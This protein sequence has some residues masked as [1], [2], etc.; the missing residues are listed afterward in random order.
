[1]PRHAFPVLKETDMRVWLAAAIVAVAPA[2]TAELT[3]DAIDNAAWHQPGKRPEKGPTALLVKAQVLLA[4]AR[5]SPGEIDG[6]PGAN[7]E[8]AV[9]AFAAARGLD[10]SA[11]LT[12]Q[13]WRELGG[14]STDPVLQEYAL[15]EKDVQGPYLDRV[16]AK[17]DKMKGLSRM[18]YGSAREAMA[19][20]FHMSEALLQKLNPRQTFATAGEKIRVVNVGDEK[21]G[22][23]AAALEI[24]KSAQ[25][26]KAFDQDHKLIAFFP[27][28]AGS[29][30]RPAPSGELKIRSV[31][32]NPTYRYNPKYAFKGV[33]SR[34][35]FKIGPG[36]NNPVGL[37]WIALPGEGYGIHGTPDPGRI[38]KSESHGCIRLTNWDVLQLADLV[39][40]GTPVNLVG[41]ETHKSRP[42]RHG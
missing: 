38:G 34:T 14:S 17:L 30:E 33:H 39:S 4:R 15:T 31:T 27:I 26:L 24:D 5:F 32:R 25:T 18:A 7:Y 23:K 3:P 21:P 35:P 13:V 37:V 11:G 1:M 12:E 42:R 9:A 19:E 22:A 29:T 16:P 40:K 8:K 10:A 28:T 6:R 36:P 20:R 41:D 2:L